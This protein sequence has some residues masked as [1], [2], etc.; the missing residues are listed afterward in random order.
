MLLDTFKYSSSLLSVLMPSWAPFSCSAGELKWTFEVNWRS[1]QNDSVRN[2]SWFPGCPLR[3]MGGDQSFTQLALE[4]L[5]PLGE[6]QYVCNPIPFVG[7][8]LFCDLSL[9]P[10]PSSPH[11]SSS[12]YY[13]SRQRGNRWSPTEE[14]PKLPSSPAGWNPSFL[15]S[16][17]WVLL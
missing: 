16:T 2:T 13:F 6:L 9:S 17:W 10:F 3:G 15:S 14:A 11:L 7:P 12:P 1:G 5:S 4:I 8:C